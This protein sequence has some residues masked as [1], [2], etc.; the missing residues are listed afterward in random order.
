M[1]K[2]KESRKASIDKMVTYHKAGYSYAAIARYFGV[3]RQCV[4]ITLLRAGKI[5]PH[6][7]REIEKIAVSC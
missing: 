2:Q 6:K 5:K 4:Y 3:T 7:A 1:I